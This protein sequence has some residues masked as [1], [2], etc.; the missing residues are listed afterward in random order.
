MNLDLS[1]LEVDILYR[2]SI[3]RLFARS[4]TYSWSSQ[5]GRHLY[6]VLLLKSGAC[7]FMH[8][9]I[10]ALNSS[11]LVGKSVAKVKLS[12]SEVASSL[13]KLERLMDLYRRLGEDKFQSKCSTLVSMENTLFFTV[14]RIAILRCC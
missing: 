11:T 3:L 10:Q 6:F 13:R 4:M 8:C 7:L 1:N 14:F 12:S 9:C 2:F 5:G